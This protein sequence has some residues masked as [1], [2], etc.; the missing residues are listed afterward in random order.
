MC[1]RDS[2]DDLANDED[3][4]KHAPREATME[5]LLDAID[6]EFGGVPALLR[7]HG[8]TEADAAALRHKLL[9]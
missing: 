8:W 5:R 3:V 6:D 7:K 4:G 2:A 1:I 9:D